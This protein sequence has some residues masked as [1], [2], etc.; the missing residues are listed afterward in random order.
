ME[1]FLGM[2]VIIIS[3]ISTYLIIA[4]Y[5]FNFSLADFREYEKT[6]ILISL[7]WAVILVISHKK[8]KK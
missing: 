3:L 4:T 5:K 2:A 6:Y 7:I 8:E 1:L